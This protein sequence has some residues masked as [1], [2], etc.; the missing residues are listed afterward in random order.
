[1]KMMTNHMPFRGDFS[2]IRDEH[3]RSMLRDAYSAVESVLGGWDALI[4]CPSPGGFMFNIPERGSIREQINIA[5]SETNTGGLHS[6]ASYSYTMRQMQGIANLGW[7]HFVSLWINADAADGNVTNN[8]SSNNIIFTDVPMTTSDTE[9]IC[10]ICFDPLE[11]NIVVL[12]N[13][14]PH[15]NASCCGHKYHRECIQG[16]ITHRHDTCPA[17]RANIVEI[18]PLLA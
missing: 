9:N 3:T 2:F 5:L 15:E 14:I 16:W 1:M 18:R 4:P 7:D 12:C 13:S 8:T 10:R 11:S 6:G 17:C